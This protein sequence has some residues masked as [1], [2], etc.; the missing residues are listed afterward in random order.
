MYSHISDPQGG[1][2]RLRRERRETFARPEPKS[3]SSET[4]G[5]CVFAQVWGF[6]SV[7]IFKCK[8]IYIFN[9]IPNLR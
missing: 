7:S 2:N 6:F 3:H 9:Q 4:Y 5:L 8:N 1:S